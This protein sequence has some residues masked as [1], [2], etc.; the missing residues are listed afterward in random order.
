MT[1]DLTYE[2]SEPLTQWLH[3]I[4]RPEGALKIKMHVSPRN[5]TSV[6]CSYTKQRS[7]EEVVITGLA[8]DG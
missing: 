2:Y 1:F 5:T 3:D 6:L 4:C 8:S 7:F